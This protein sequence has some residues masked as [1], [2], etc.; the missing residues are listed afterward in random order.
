[1]KNSF[2]FYLLL[3]ILAILAG[4]QTVPQKTLPPLKIQTVTLEELITK[5]NESSAGLHSVKSTLNI[6]VREREAQ[7][8]RECQGLLAYVKPDK[9]YLKG[10]RP[11]IPTFF[12]MV[13]KDGTFW[14]HLPKD[15]SVLT[16]KVSDL[17]ASQNLE[18]GIRPDD[19]ERALN[20]HP[21]PTSTDYVV[22]MQEAP[23]Q[24]I[25]SVFRTNGTGKF[26]ERQIWIERF[27]LNVEREVYLNA[28][29]VAEVDITR[30][31]YMNENKIY[32]P[33]EIAIYRPDRGSTLFLK[34][35]KLTIN[36]ELNPKLFN[37][38]MPGGATVEELKK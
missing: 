30:K 4:C 38:E 24:Y 8:A 31:N 29:G 10:Y 6:R 32:F 9:I 22:E 37:F 33:Q 25:L 35:N 13:S 36:P 15:N 23:A 3:M 1:M 18:M 5:I 20:I 34:V 7:E 26:L 14:V 28:Y 12:T 16:G 19:L 11:L 27:F 17:N 21:L 2:R